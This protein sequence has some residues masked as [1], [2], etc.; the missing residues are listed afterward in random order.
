MFWLHAVGVPQARHGRPWGGHLSVSHIFGWTLGVDL[1]QQPLPGERVSR[2]PDALHRGAGRVRGLLHEST[3][4]VKS[5][6][7][8]GKLQK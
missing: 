1:D 5:Q 2:C 7:A 6:N 8:K 3:E 4:Q